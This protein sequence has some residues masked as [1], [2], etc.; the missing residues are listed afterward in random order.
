[1]NSAI[2]NNIF[3]GTAFVFFIS[4]AAGVPVF[5]LLN[6]FFYRS[7]GLPG[8]LYYNNV[9]IGDGLV[10]PLFNALLYY[11]LS[12]G[13][14]HWSWLPV[15][16]S[17]ISAIILTS[18]FIYWRIYINPVNDWSRPVFGKINGAGIYHAVYFFVQSIIAGIAFFLCIFQQSWQELFY[19]CSVF[20]IYGMLAIF[21]EW[22][23]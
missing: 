4:V 9:L 15:L 18:G 2:I 12:N 7:N 16:L 13:K 10:F 22:R 1:M 21:P 6:R 8:A 3:S 14:L 19:F 5:Y 20:S 23:P 11:F 17:M